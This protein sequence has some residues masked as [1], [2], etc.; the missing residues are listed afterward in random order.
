MVTDS[1]AFT[2][3]VENAT[4]KT[5]RHKADDASL[6]AEAHVRNHIRAHGALRFERIIGANHFYAFQQNGSRSQ[7]VFAV[8]AR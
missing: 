1:K 3:T 5:C 8:R 7:R 4:G 2:Y 6:A